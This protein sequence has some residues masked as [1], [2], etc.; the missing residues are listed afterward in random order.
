[1]FW[2]RKNKKNVPD[3][4]VLQQLQKVTDTEKLL[5]DYAYKLK[6]LWDKN[7]SGNSNHFPILQTP[8]GPLHF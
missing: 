4:E 2:K 6:E 3:K 5:Y 1:M 8:M 7:K